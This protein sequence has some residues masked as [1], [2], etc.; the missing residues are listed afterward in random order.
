MYIK[1]QIYSPSQIIFQNWN[2][3]TVQ[4]TLGNRITP[5][6]LPITHDWLL[7]QRKG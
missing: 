2:I 1:A 4:F 6:N 5:E 7:R 3:G